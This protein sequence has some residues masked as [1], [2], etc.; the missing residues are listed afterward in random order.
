MDDDAP[1]RVSLTDFHSLLDHLRSIDLVVAGGV[2]QV[3][4]GGGAGEEVVQVQAGNVLAGRVEVVLPRKRWVPR[5]LEWVR[6]WPLDPFAQ[7]VLHTCVL[8]ALNTDRQ[9]VSCIPAL[10]VVE[11]Y[12]AGG[13][14][15]QD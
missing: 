14:S 3:D 5:W 12:R 10:F 2:G 13:G 9:K 6:S 15:C 8:D 4:D 11:W 1:G 7:I